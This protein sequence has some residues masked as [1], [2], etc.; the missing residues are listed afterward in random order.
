L[1]PASK[2]VFDEETWSAF[3]EDYIS[4]ITQHGVLPA[5]AKVGAEHFAAR[6]NR[7]K[8]NTDALEQFAK[9]LETWYGNT[10]KG[11]EL[12][13]V[14]QYLAQRINDFIAANQPEN[15]LTSF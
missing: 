15:V 11:E 9:R 3:K 12:M 8:G 2:T 6:L 5:Q 10:R 4:V 7:V 1:P 13:K 14:Y